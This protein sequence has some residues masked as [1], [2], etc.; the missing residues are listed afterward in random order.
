M[1]AFH[2][3]G[4]AAGRSSRGLRSTGGRSN[5]KDS[6][7][8]FGGSVVL[9]RPMPG[10]RRLRHLMFR[11]RLRRRRVAS[12]III[13]SL[14]YISLAS[15]LPAKAFCTATAILARS[16]F[17]APA[18]QRRTASTT[19]VRLSEI[20]LTARGRAGSAV[21][22]GSTKAICLAATP[23]PPSAT[24]VLVTLMPSA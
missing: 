18:I 20:T 12:T 13:R 3:Q 15:V 24:R 22:L 5:G 2:V 17:L 8:G 7:R 23:L 1:P 4:Q 6:S 10:R 21:R 14:G 9:D 11:A 16:T 19:A